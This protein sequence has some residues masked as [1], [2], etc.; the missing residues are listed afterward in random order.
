MT[1]GA[2]WTRHGN[3]IEGNAMIFPA[4]TN[5]TGVLKRAL[6]AAPLALGLAGCQ[7]L[8][9]GQSPSGGYGPQSSYGQAAGNTPLA[10]L[11]PAQAQRLNAI[12]APLL[13]HMNRPLRPDQVKVTVM[14]DSHVN[15]A[16]G[17]A[18]DFYVTTG[19]LQKANDA[20]LRAI[21]AHEIAHAD[22]GHV[23]KMQTAGL[24]VGIGAAILGALWPGTEQL[25]PIAGELVLSHYSR[26][27]ES[28]ADQHGVEI[29]NRA[30]Y[31]GRQM[32]VSALTWLA[33]TEGNNGGGFFETHPATSDRI[34]ALSAMR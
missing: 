19:L 33:N 4:A 25:A 9:P 11:P 15:A 28:A 29:L 32:M 20:E 3:T 17:G 27:E 23:N 21:L 34:R 2:S 30:G 1:R 14:A 24:G 16:N 26:T 6:V 31:P 5:F 18:G 10:T 12:M 7:G 8:D 22:L 13:A